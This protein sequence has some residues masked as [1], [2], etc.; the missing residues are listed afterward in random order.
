MIKVIVVGATG[1]VGRELVKAVSAATDL[2]LA[3]AVAR[4]AAGEDAGI[5]AGMP[6]LGV[7]VTASLDEALAAPADVVVDYTK[8]HVVKGH[9]LAAVGAGRHVIVGT[10][11]L[12]AA[13]YAEIDAAARAAGRGVIAAG[14]FS[15]TA[16]L[17]KRF[18]TI[19]ARHIPDV[20]IIDY[21]S[22]KK[23]DTPSGTGRELGEILSKVRLAGTAKPVGELGGI[24][25]TR[26]GAVNDGGIAVQVHSVRMPSYI[27]S[28]E[29]I[30]GL[31][32]ERLTIRHDAGASA[33]P[34]VGGTLLA[35]RK[36]GGQVGLV[37]G[38]DHLI[39]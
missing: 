30:F 10:S 35:V 17:L 26:G 4:S 32:D 6:A 39:D 18:A 16:S 7:T 1:W 21:A 31:P 15:I 8:P 37:R 12:S 22:A 33:A 2:E 29:A 20:E 3:G 36:V 11:G 24:Q 9:A 34:Y 25:E 38:I 5:A 28:A 27:L 23:P 14:N 13:D 19:A